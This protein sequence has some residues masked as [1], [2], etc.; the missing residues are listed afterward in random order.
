MITVNTDT[1]QHLESYEKSHRHVSLVKSSTRKEPTPP[2]HHASKHYEQKKLDGTKTPRLTARTH[3]E[4]FSARTFTLA[5]TAAS[6]QSYTDGRLCAR[7]V[8]P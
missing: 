4:T 3:T 8:G 6:Q 1:G 2:N 5:T 7:Q